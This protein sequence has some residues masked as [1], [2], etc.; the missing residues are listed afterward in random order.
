MTTITLDEA[1]KELPNLIKRALEG[2]D[3]IIAGEDQ[4]SA[5]RLS[6][7]PPAFDEETAR[8]RGYGSLKGKLV[9]PDSFFDPLPEDEL[10]YW[11]G[12]GDE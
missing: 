11:E 8:R 12:R 10:K 6:A 1:Q 3:I 2:E 5:V 4:R 7:V 9:V